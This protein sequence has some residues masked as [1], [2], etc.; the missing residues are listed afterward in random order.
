M[1][2]DYHRIEQAIDF[3]H[4]HAG[5][6]PA[7][8]EAA[9]AAGLSEH[10]F[11]RLFTRW[12]GISPK[13]YLQVLAAE[14]ARRLLPTSSVLDASLGAGLS[15][16]GRLH[17]LLVSLHAASPGELRDGGRGLSLRHG[18]ADTPFGE[19]LL[20]LSPRGLCHFG[21]VGDDRAAALAE[22]R[23][24]WPRAALIADDPAADALVGR[25]FP[26]RPGASAQPLALWVRGTNFQV[27]VWEALLRIAP[28]ET[29]SYQQLAATVGR[30]GAARAVGNAV[31]ANSVAYLIPCHRVIRRHAGLGD[32]RWGAPRKAA[33]LAWERCQLAAGGEAT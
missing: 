14:R 23:A 19:A 6:Q 30:P 20:A 22:L 31:G 15:G 7:L 26:H 1:Q 4:R 29:V 5:R 13:R 18:F 3:L 27:R 32:Y 9:A 33:L 17:D 10:H 21:F 24:A 25:I 28:G 12:A 8:A 16:P 2:H 11:Q